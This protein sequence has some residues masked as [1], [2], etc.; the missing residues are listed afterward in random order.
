MNWNQRNVSDNNKSDF[1][2][3]QNQRRKN[4]VGVPKKAGCHQRMS[5]YHIQYVCVWNVDGM[6]IEFDHQ[7]IC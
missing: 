2:K 5:V 3:S 4:G 6:Y 1:T 7:L